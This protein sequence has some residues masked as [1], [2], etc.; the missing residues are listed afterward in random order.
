LKCIVYCSKS[1]MIIIPELKKKLVLVG[2]II[3][4]ISLETAVKEQC[5]TVFSSAYI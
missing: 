1:E 4:L 2:K 5:S 3:F